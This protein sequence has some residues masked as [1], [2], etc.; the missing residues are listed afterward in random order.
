MLGLAGRRHRET[1]QAVGR[2]QDHLEGRR[3]GG[4][5]TRQVRARCMSDPEA[6]HWEP[7]LH[8]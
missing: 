7:G 3:P 6:R 4:G 2:A 1:G 5:G 8:L